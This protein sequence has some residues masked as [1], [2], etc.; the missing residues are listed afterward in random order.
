VL[1]KLKKCFEVLSTRAKAVRI[2]HNKAR[3]AVLFRQFTI[4]FVIFFPTNPDVLAQSTPSGCTTEAS[5]TVLSDRVHESE[6]HGSPSLLAP[7]VPQALG[8]Q[9]TLRQNFRWFIASTFGPHHLAGGIFLSAFGTALDRPKEYETH[10]GGL[11]D[12]YGILKSGVVT[13]NAIEAGAGLLLREDPRYFRVPNRPFK[14]R[15]KNV[16]WLTIAAR[17]GHSTFGPA[18]ARYMAI[19]GNNFLS[20]TWRAHSEANTRDALL[21]TSEGFAGRMAANA[22]EEFW[23]DVKKLLLRTRN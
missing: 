6:G 8:Q 23:P 16:V 17:R 7:M 9:I 14:A 3:G 18:Y 4:L 22:F 1:K 21:R 13:G 5:Q 11:G 10:W 19:A 2:R 15:L 12:R 20:N